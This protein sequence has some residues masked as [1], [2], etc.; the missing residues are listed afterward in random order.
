M[1][2]QD[3]VEY[4]FFILFKFVMFRCDDTQDQNILSMFSMLLN[5]HTRSISIRYKTYYGCVMNISKKKKKC[6]VNHFNSSSSVRT[7]GVLEGA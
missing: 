4:A 7:H 5:W 3:N 2:E 6:C 1:T